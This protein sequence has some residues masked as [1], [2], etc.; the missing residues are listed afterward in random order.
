MKLSNKETVA[1]ESILGL[2]IDHYVDIIGGFPDP[3]E[4]DLVELL[5]GINDRLVVWNETTRQ[6]E[7]E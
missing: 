7:G 5:N 3:E 6:L 1:L 2:A 4:K